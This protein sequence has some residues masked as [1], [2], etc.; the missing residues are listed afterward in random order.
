MNLWRRSKINSE[1][2][3]FEE[4]EEIMTA[5]YNLLDDCA[6][7]PLWHRKLQ[8]DLGQSVAFLGIMMEEAKVEGDGTEQI[9]HPNHDRFEA[10]KQVYFK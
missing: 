9:K 5:Y 6:E 8:E 10:E 2:L 1:H 4:M 3:L 7:Y